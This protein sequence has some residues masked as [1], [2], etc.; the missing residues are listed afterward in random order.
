[1]NKEW[2]EEGLEFDAEVTVSDLKLY[3]IQVV[4]NKDNE[5]DNDE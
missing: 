5:E 3:G 1:M 2:S 4:S